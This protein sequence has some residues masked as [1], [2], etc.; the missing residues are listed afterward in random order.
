MHISKA[1]AFSDTVLSD[2]SMMLDATLLLDE[3][4]IVYRLAAQIGV[5]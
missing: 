2:G 1:A 4:G 5:D 3:V